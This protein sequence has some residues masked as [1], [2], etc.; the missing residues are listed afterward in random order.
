MATVIAVVSSNHSIPKR[1]AVDVE[2]SVP[3]QGAG[4][5]LKP[6]KMRGL[7]ERTREGYP[8]GCSRGRHTPA[9]LTLGPQRSCRRGQAQHQKDC[10]T[11]GEQAGLIGRQIV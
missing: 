10:L 1:L 9:A 8:C 3:A 11:G 4:G 6:A 5:K 2:S 7:G